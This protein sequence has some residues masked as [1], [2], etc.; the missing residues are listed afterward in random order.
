M[1][2]RFYNMTTQQKISD[3]IVIAEKLLEYNS[4]M[5]IEISKKDDFKYN[6]GKGVEVALALHAERSLVKV[7]TYKPKW[8]FSK[9]IGYSDG[10]AIYVNLRK[11]PEMSVIDVASNLLHEMAH[12]AGFNHSNNYKTQDKVLYS[13]PY[14]LSENI[15]KWM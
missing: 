7:F 4:A 3:A 2:T 13:V 6:S 9:A 12:H 5:L 15:S 14:Y 10:K 11:L 8:V 1:N